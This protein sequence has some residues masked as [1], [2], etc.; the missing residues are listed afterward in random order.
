M[1]KQATLKNKFWILVIIVFFSIGGF[2]LKAVYL[3]MVKSDQ[4][5]E[6]KEEKY[7]RKHTVKAPRGK[8]YDRNGKLIAQNM[9]FYKLYCEPD[10]L[11]SA[12]DKVYHFLINLFPEDKENIQEK[13]NSKKTVV[14]KRKV[15]IQTA[16]K[17]N[18][19]REKEKIAFLYLKPF[20]RRI[21]PY[22]SYAGQV[23]GFVNAENQGVHGIERA[24][25]EYLTG[26]DGY[27][28]LNVTP[29][30]VAWE[31][32][33]I[34][35]KKP[36]PGNN[37]YLTI[38]L[39]LQAIA[40]EELSNA[41]KKYKAKGGMVVILKSKTSEVLSIASIP[42][43]DPNHPG[44]YNSFERKNRAITDIFEP[45]STFKPLVAAALIEK[46]K[47]GLDS[48]IYCE[49]GAYQVYRTVFHDHKKYG[50]LTFKKVLANSS[51]IGMIKTTMDYMTD[52]GLYT[53]LHSL[54]FGKKTG[55]ELPGESG[56]ILHE[57]SNW[58]GITRASLSFGH[59]IGVTAIQLTNAY[60]TI[61]NGGKLMKP[62]LVKFI[63]DA[64]GDVVK[65]NKPTVIAEIFSEE[66]SDKIKIALSDAVEDGTAVK[67]KVENLDVAGKTGTAQK[68]N[69]SGSGYSQTQYVSSFIGFFP[70]SNPE[71][72]ILVMLDSPQ[73]P[74][75]TGGSSAAP[76]FQNIVKKIIGLPSFTKYLGR[77]DNPEQSVFLPDLRGYKVAN[78]ISV[79]KRLGL[80]YD[81]LGKGEI[82]KDVN[83]FNTYISKDTQVELIVTESIKK[84]NT[85]P[86]FRGKPLREVIAI[87]NELK[88]PFSIEGSGVVKTQYPNA[89]VN[90]DKVTNL[91]LVCRAG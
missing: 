37:V 19:F 63:E 86:D 27:Y 38:D 18:A 76:T 88:I 83:Y 90:L 34:Q 71:L 51:N 5:S 61:A 33:D 89:G 68:L 52:K 44:D 69:K 64:D 65:E 16:K 43:F 80:N 42:K 23:I 75:H 9:L 2:W 1:A 84:A 60:G 56:G 25:N 11:E 66:T 79:L 14:I 39:D 46:Q 4:F 47:V 3:Q 57:P 24:F 59:E 7:L 73:A 70:V 17:I 62:S 72:I 49:N 78:A 82:V 22:Q 20:Y 12:R 8:I 74:H 55:I 85:L 30:W 45:G 48:I 91:K 29:K 50:W 36:I 10:K 31:N 67:A 21:Y 28:Y 40:E 77:S 13:F 81:V 41:V 6:W 58:S 87:L 15:D 32:I 54:G 26:Q 35:G 53:F